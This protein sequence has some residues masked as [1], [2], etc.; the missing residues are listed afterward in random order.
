MRELTIGV[1]SVPSPCYH[2]V[3]NVFN[4][5]GTQ[6]VVN[7][8]HHD[9][10]LSMYLYLYFTYFMYFTFLTHFGTFCVSSYLLTSL[11]IFS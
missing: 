8:M 2:V 3:F 11:L 1:M 7:G 5:F 10:H 6:Y 9:W 4:V